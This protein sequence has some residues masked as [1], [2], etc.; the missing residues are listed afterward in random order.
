M[1]NDAYDLVL[2]GGLVVG[3][4]VFCLLVPGSALFPTRMPHPEA[5]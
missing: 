3:Y 2:R 5:H 4:L 1:Q